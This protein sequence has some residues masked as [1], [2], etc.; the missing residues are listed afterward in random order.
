MKIE[1]S[2]LLTRVPAIAS[3]CE[4]QMVPERL[5]GFTAYVSM[6]R[7]QRRWIQWYLLWNNVWRRIGVVCVFTYGSHRVL[8]R[9]KHFSHWG[10]GN[11]VREVC[12]S[13]RTWRW[14]IVD[15]AS[16]DDATSAPFTTINT[17]SPRRFPLDFFSFSNALFATFLFQLSPF[18]STATSFFL[19]SCQPLQNQL[20]IHQLFFISSPNFEIYL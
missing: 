9:C 1:S 13:I 17:R 16:I 18:S 10:P 6:E 19:H 4:V 3:N 5:G 15:I 8:S 20:D 7:Y 14:M 2:Q 11:I 12:L